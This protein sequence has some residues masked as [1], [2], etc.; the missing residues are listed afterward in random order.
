MVKLNKIHYVIYIIVLIMISEYIVLKF[1]KLPEYHSNVVFA[2]DYN[3]NNPN[4]H[5][6]SK[7]PGLQFELKPNTYS[8]WQGAKTYINSKGLRD[9]EYK[10]PKP[11]NTFRIIGLGDSVTF[12]A[13]I[14]QNDTFLNLIEHE[15]NNYYDKNIEVLNAGVSAYNSLQQYIN[16]L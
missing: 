5:Q 12:G 15:L 13:S 4:I 2:V 6:M 7:I 14:D 11:D 16:D 8:I 10:I 1:E 3:P 9:K